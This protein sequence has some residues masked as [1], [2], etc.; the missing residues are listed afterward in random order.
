MT[1]NKK[2]ETEVKEIK[3]TETV[4]KSVPEVKESA[5]V[6]LSDLNNKEAELKKE[7]A[8]VKTSKYEMTKEAPAAE[9]SLAKLIMEQRRMRKVSETE[10]LMKKAVMAQA[11]KMS[12]AN[13]IGASPLNPIVINKGK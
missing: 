5:T 8:K 7:L 2:K 1:E 10:Y 3:A 4:N 12:N 6:S 9:K 11:R 13:A